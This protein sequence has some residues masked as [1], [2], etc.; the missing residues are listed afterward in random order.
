MRQSLYFSVTCP[1]PEI[2]NKITAGEHY[3]ARVQDSPSRY[4]VGAYIDFACYEGMRSGPFSI[5]C[6]NTGTWNG[7]PAICGDNFIINLSYKNCILKNNLP[8]N[9]NV[10]VLN[11][12]CFGSL[13]L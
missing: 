3:L 8:N 2:S 12:R 1:R 10:I 5:Q 4:R 13:K 6:Q 7:E 9:L 11:L